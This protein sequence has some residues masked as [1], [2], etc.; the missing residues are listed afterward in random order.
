MRLNKSSIQKLRSLA[1]VPPIEINLE[2]VIDLYKHNSFYI[3]KSAF[4]E[5]NYWLDDLK[6]YFRVKDESQ[7]RLIIHQMLGVV[8]IL[9]SSHLTEQIR[10]AQVDVKTNRFNVDNL[11]L[12]TNQLRSGYRYYLKKLYQ[13]KTSYIRVVVSGTNRDQIYQIGLVIKGLKQIRLVKQTTNVDELE[14][15]IH[16]C[17]P[18]VLIL[19]EKDKELSQKTEISSISMEYLGTSIISVDADALQNSQIQMKELSTLIMNSLLQ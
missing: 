19:V 18:E 1:R 16:E 10:K 3:T 17:L 7:A 9:K 8:Q 13:Q 14:N 11:N 2:H 12:L 4:K 6:H 5:L 15:L